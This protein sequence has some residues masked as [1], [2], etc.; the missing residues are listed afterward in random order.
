M[1]IF[2][3]ILLYALMY[4]ISLNLNLTATLNKMISKHIAIIKNCSVYMTFISL[5]LDG[6]DGA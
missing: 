5:N 3:G 4:I 2:P 6:V 1:T